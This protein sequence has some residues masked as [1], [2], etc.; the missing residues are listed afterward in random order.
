MNFFAGFI[1]SSVVYY[2]CCRF[3]PIPAT[4]DHWLEV[5]DEIRN[6][7]V[8]YDNDGSS[9]DIEAEAG[10]DKGVQEGVLPIDKKVEIQDF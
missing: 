9:G 7:S 6:L 4:S 2:L 8:A 3:S 1:V 10:Y 5:G